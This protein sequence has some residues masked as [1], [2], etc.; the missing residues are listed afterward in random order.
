MTSM[1]NRRGFIGAAVAGAAGLTVAPA[2]LSAIGP[3]PGVIHLN[4]NENPYGPS[5][6]A[7][8]AAAQASEVGAYYAGGINREL[9]QVIA[10]ENEVSLNHLAISSGSN[11]VLSAAVVAWG[12]SGRIVAPSL[13]YDYHMQ[14]AEGTGTQVD[15][16]PLKPDMSIDLGALE[17]AVDDTVSMVYVCN[18]NNPTG[19]LI[20]GDE[21]R[22][23]CQRVGKKATVLVDE[24]YTEL[25]DDPAYSS[26]LDLVRQGES[27][28]ITRTFSKL[29]GMAGFRVG[30][31]IAR[32]DLAARV[33]NY[34]MAWP[35]VVGLAAAKASFEDQAF[36]NY[37]RAR[38][39][40]G[41]KIVSDTFVRNGFEPLPSQANF[42]YAD[43]RRN[44]DDFGA[45]LRENNIRIH[46]SF[47]GHP[48]YARVS[49]SIVE[50]LHVF[51]DV[52][53]DL[54]RT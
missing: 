2:V 20:D 25:T 4:S 31:A 42:V 54:I 45:L 37:S 39:L 50:D 3:A 27:I 5:A 41:R 47:P 23:F 44:V 7:L 6:S 53:D 1:L 43:I 28:I 36:R 15:R 24:A 26:M 34:V 48:T 17:R 32:P 14:Y 38:I 12:K 35:N 51:A 40:E 13:T 30:Y 10:D 9:R 18:P 22:D 33:R 21:L 49:M 46:S 16:V 19:M 29:H 8:R 52:F 11:E